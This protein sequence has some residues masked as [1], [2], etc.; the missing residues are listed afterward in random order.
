MNIALGAKIKDVDEINRT[1]IGPVKMPNTGFAASEGVLES[2]YPSHRELRAL[3]RSADFDEF[4]KMRTE[5]SKAK[6]HDVFIDPIKNRDLPKKVRFRLRIIETI[7]RHLRA[8]DSDVCNICYVFRSLL[9]WK[10][11]CEP[12]LSMVF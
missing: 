5:R 1:E 3:I 11:A 7:C 9:H 6:R 10:S 2:F 12:F 4:Y 8:F